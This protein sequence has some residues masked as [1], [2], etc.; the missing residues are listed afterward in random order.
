MT[1]S[2]LRYGIFST[3][4]LNVP[5]PHAGAGRARETAHMELVD[6]GLVDGAFQRL[7]ALPV[8]LPWIDH[9]TA[10]RRVQIVLRA[11]GAGAFPQ[12]LADAACVRADLDLLGLNRWPS[13]GA[14]GPST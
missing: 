9:G 2:D 8:V 13:A 11:H 5:V 14:T 7:I 12:L 10:H 6:D 1:P 3:T 4:P